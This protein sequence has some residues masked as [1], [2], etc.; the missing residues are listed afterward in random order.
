MGRQ[1]VNHV[2]KIEKMST[3]ESRDKNRKK[4]GDREMGKW[5]IMGTKTQ[6]KMCFVTG[7]LGNF[8]NGVGCQH[9]NHVIKIEKKI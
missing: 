9:V 1:H 7:N 6:G 8:V 4:Y 2:I 5:G 3:R